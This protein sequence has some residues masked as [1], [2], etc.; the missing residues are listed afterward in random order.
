MKIKDIIIM[1][2][3]MCLFIW[4][5]ENYGLLSGVLGWLLID[6]L[7]IGSALILYKEQR[8]TLYFTFMAGVRNIEILLFGHLNE[9]KLTGGKNGK[10][11]NKKT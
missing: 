10:R 1:I 7:F 5:W 2:I 11:T 6:I 3:R 8:E 4:I 9:P